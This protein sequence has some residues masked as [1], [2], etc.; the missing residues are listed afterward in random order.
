MNKETD[1]QSQW[2]AL[3]QDR[4]EIG[5]IRPDGKMWQD[6]RRLSNMLSKLERYSFANESGRENIYIRAIPSS[7]HDI[8]FLDDLS[9][10]GIVFLKENGI[11]PACAVETSS[12][13]FQAWFRLSEKQPRETRKAVERHLIGLLG[14]NGHHA[15]SGSADG[16]HYGRLCC[17]INQKPGRNGFRVALIE[18]SGIILTPETTAYLLQQSLVTATKNLAVAGDCYPSLDQIR[19]HEYEHPEIV[20]FFQRLLPSIQQGRDPSAVDFML[21]ARCAKEGFGKEDIQKA[22]V[23][24]GPNDLTRKNK[25]GYYITKTVNVAIAREQQP[26]VTAT[27][28]PKP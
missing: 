8:I 13:N 22:L 24:I 17:F 4:Y 28:G 18:A 11:A 26:L 14:E 10:G 7:E 16:M 2:G 6:V 27:V 23:E 9:I 20:E 19:A 3:G 25:P 15:D 21:A 12:E 1:I 5:Q